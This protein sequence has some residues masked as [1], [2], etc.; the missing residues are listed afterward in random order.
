MC[1]LYNKMSPFGILLAG[2]AFV[3]IRAV[4]LLSREQTRTSCA[5][6]SD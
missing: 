4:L 3:I 6:L 2:V 5:S 1:N